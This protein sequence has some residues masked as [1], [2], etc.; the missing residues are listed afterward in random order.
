M[1]APRELKPCILAMIVSFMV[2]VESRLVTKAQTG[3]SEYLDPHNAARGVVGAP[4]L[5][6]SAYL[7]DY[8]RAYAETQVTRCV[9]FV[10]GEFVLGVGGEGVD[11]AGRRHR[12]DG[13][14]CGLRLPQERVQA[15]E[16]VWTLHA[17]GVEVHHACRMRSSS[18]QRWRGLRH[19]QLRP[20]RKLD[21]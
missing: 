15:G 6:W 7:A 5:R 2:L 12:L 3:I 4:A 19:L 20:A 1:S 18:V 16:D 8:A 10:R 14:G 13:R 17:G 9:E 21:R 11:S